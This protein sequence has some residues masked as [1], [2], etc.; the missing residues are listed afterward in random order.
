MFSVFV[1]QVPDTRL[2]HV[3]PPSHDQY[4]HQ[5]QIGNA[6]S[7]TLVLT[8]YTLKTPGRASKIYL[9]ARYFQDKCINQLSPPSPSCPPFLLSLYTTV[10]KSQLL[11]R[12]S[13]CVT[14]NVLC[15]S[16]SKGLVVGLV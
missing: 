16:F 6:V 11:V 12:V 4:D 9:Y 13:S 15:S 5:T 10:L 1:N 2:C 8:C 3:G 14:P 7:G